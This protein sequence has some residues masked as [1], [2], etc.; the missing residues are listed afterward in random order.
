MHFALMTTIPLLSS[1]CNEEGRIQCEV[2]CIIDPS[3][4]QTT[5]NVLIQLCTQLR[6]K[7]DELAYSCLSI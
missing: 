1:Y 4:A 3:S 2:M 7:V 5:A 6:V